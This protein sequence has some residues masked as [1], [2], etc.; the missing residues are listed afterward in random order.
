MKSKTAKLL[1]QVALCLTSVPL[2]AQL[3]KVEGGVALSKQVL[4]EHDKTD[5]SDIII[6]YQFC[7]KADIPVSMTLCLQPGISLKQMGSTFFTTGNRNNI[8][9][10][11]TT[12]TRVTYLQVPVSLIFRCDINPDMKVL[13]GTGTYAAYALKGR[14]QV[15]ESNSR[16][17]AVSVSSPLAGNDA[18]NSIRRMDYGLVFTSGLDFAN[19]LSINGQYQAGLCNL[20]PSGVTG[21]KITNQSFMMTLGYYI[22]RK[23][24]TKMLSSR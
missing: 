5:I 4:K 21:K 22:N 10:D 20:T 6:G 19:G 15:L 16:M 18:A 24:F 13:F 9:S 7:V 14:R 3:I 1:L 12:T 8:I 11:I 23:A 17:E 2:S